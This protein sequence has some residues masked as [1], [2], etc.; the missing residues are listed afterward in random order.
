MDSKRTKVELL[1]ACHPNIPFDTRF[2]T[3]LT[4]NDPSFLVHIC[5]RALARFMVVDRLLVQ[6]T[7][8]KGRLRGVYE[9]VH[10]GSH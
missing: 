10:V 9:F 4:E 8:Q 3:V 2:E 7:L 6:V 5:H 1:E